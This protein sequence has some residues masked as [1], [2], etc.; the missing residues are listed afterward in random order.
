MILSN[1]GTA[2]DYVSAM[3]LEIERKFLIEHDGWKA[4]RTRS[5]RIRDG[6]IAS[7]NGRKV[8]VRIDPLPIST[9]T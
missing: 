7:E 5:I 4:S 2:E 1:K 6:L 8:R 9:S 3:P